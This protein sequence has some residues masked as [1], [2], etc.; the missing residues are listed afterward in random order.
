[1]KASD[2]LPR[3]AVSGS[4]AAGA[5]QMAGHDSVTSLPSLSHGRHP[6]S[7]PSSN[8]QYRSKPI[9]PETGVN[10]QTSLQGESTPLPSEWTQKQLE[11]AEE[12]KR[13]KVQ[14]ENEIARHILSLYASTTALRNLKESNSLLDF[15]G[16]KVNKHQQENTIKTSVPSFSQQHGDTMEDVEEGEYG[17]E[18]DA[19][20]HDG[21][22]VDK[23]AAAAKDG[24]KKKK[25]KKKKKKKKIVEEDSTPNLSVSHSRLQKQS[26][27][28]EILGKI[29]NY[30]NISNQKDEYRVTNTIVARNG[31]IITVRGSP[32][33]YPIWFTSTGDVYADWTR[34][35]G[36]R[37]LQA[38]LSSLYERAHY[39]EYLQI[40]ETIIIEL[41]RLK[42]YGPQEFGVGSFGISSYTQDFSKDVGSNRKKKK[43][44]GHSGTHSRHAMDKRSQQR[45]IDKVIV[46]NVSQDVIQDINQH[47]DPKSAFSTTSGTFPT[48]PEEDEAQRN[49]TGG[50]DGDDLTLEDVVE[51]F[52]QLIFTT[53]A[54]VVVCIE[55][56][57][58]EI[59]IS[60]LNRAE[61]FCANKE[62]LER[63]SV[64]KFFK[65]HVCNAMA[66]YFYKRKK[67]LAAQEYVNRAMET[68]EVV[69]DFEGVGTCLLHLGAIFTNLTK[70]K[71][72]HKI[73]YQFLAM[74]E[75]GRLSTL[76]ASP[77]QL[78]MVS[79]A[80]HNLAVVQL[81]MDTSDL[82]CK[83]SQNAR[84]IARLCLSHSNR[85][86]ETFQFTHK[87]AISDMKYDL[88][89]RDC[90][91]YTQEQLQVIKE[92]SEALFAIDADVLKQPDGQGGEVSFSL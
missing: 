26:L 3:I 33:C 51:L 56:N 58:F 59:A 64:R 88:S 83:S 23:A 82:A 67:L 81:K 57:M 48:I 72:A 89:T 12:V 91:D 10:V 19:G 4:K 84:K 36:R 80:Y 74:V 18:D 42:K 76:N 79:V 39:K 66:Y 60:F 90:D 54:I 6:S 92:L 73:M 11:M 9:I 68:F 86:I 50:T 61:Q 47:M 65:A 77:K 52:Q 14:W 27:V 49:P 78:C 46:D 75:S 87:V 17:Y 32:R 34:L 30:A 70:F 29:N 63:G 38:H 71:E 69:Q 7:A 24:L 15:V 2:S 20:H 28:D 31:Q 53:L 40:L 41:F 22:E 35:P 16:E 5:G 43:A 55:K 13:T 44:L 1:M 62:V 45:W 25:R 8:S 37:H 85:Y 21:A